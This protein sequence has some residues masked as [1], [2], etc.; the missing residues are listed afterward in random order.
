MT[1]TPTEER[2]PFEAKVTANLD[3]TPRGDLIDSIVNLVEGRLAPKIALV[4]DPVSNT[5]ALVALKPDGTFQTIPASVFDD[6]L[7]GP[8]FRRGKSTVTDLDSFIAMTNRFKDE[9]S[10]VFANDERA[11]PS[12][13]AVFDYHGANIPTEEGIAT[14]SP[15][16]MKHRTFF[17]IPTSDEWKA[18]NKSN[19]KVN[20]M[21]VGE[22]AMFLEDRIGDVAAPGEL[23]LSP[24]AKTYIDRIGGPDRIASPSD[25][26]LLSKGLSIN[27]N[28]AITD[29]RKLESGEGN[30][31]FSTEHTDSDGRPLSIPTSFQ[32]AIPVFHNGPLYA[33][34]VRLRYRVLQGSLTLWYELWRP[35]LSFDDA[36]DDSVMT[37][38]EETGLPLFMGAPEA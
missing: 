8:R 6:Y 22:F 4:E 29:F 16:H 28:S 1:D 11:S 20:A 38:K 17:A 14:C 13:L 30:I 18:W 37:V 10:A 26:I 23:P 15:R 12:L 32:I 9:Q 34:V 33:M 36:F 2:G 31:S 3:V 7:D 27:E 25:L 35:D 21:D 5:K 24:A 19:G